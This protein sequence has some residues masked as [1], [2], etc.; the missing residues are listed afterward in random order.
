MSRPVPPFTTNYHIDLQV[1][2]DD[3]VDD[4]VTPGNSSRNS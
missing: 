3:A 2:L 1:D 4:D